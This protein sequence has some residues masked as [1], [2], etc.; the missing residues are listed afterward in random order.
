[1]TQLQVSAGASGVLLGAIGAAQ[2]LNLVVK[3]LQGRI[4]LHVMLPQGAGGLISPHVPQRIGRLL[5]LTQ[6]SE[7]RHVNAGTWWARGTRGSSITRRTLK[8]GKN[9]KLDLTKIKKMTELMPASED[10]S[11]CL[12]FFLSYYIQQDQF[13]QSVHEVQEVRW[14]RVVRCFHPCQQVQLVQGVPAETVRVSV[15]VTDIKWKL[16]HLLNLCSWF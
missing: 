15:K 13:L 2:V 4:D 7:G 12:S 10:R 5:S 1:M 6:A 8:E 11:F 14:G 9:R 16:F 3:G